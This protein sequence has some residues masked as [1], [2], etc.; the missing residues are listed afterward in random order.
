MPK[1]DELNAAMSILETG[2]AQLGL[3]LNADQLAR[4]KRYIEDLADYNKVTNLVSKATPKILV[5]EH[6]LDSL[7]LVPAVQAFFAGPA[8]AHCLAEPASATTQ[9]E[10][11]EH[12]RSLIDIGSGAGFPG[13]I[14]AIALPDLF[15]TL[16]DSIE[17]KTRFLIREA[18]KLDLKNVEVWTDR[19]EEIAHHPQCRGSFDLATGRAVGALDM[20]A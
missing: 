2:A 7:T 17:K 3:K 12:Q 19:V 10:K 6:I 20:V 11:Q 18:H 4:L 5:E 1:D 8:G 13:L 14:L 9:P 15:T 16:V